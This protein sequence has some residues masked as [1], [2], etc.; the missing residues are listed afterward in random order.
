MDNKSKI[1]KPKGNGIYISISEILEYQYKLFAFELY[2]IL[3][4]QIDKHQQTKGDVK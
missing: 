3:G 1:N 2:E 4:I